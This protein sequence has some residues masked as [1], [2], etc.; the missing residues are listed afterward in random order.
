MEQDWQ[1]H[2]KIRKLNNIFKKSILEFIRTSQNSVY[3]CQNTKRIK[4][5]ARLK[6]GLIPLCGQKFNHSFQDTIN[7]MCNCG[8]DIVEISR[9]RLLQER[10]TLFYGFLPRYITT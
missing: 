3:N 7:L 10:M 2:P 4:K 9:S 6:V 8:E 5:L 1:K